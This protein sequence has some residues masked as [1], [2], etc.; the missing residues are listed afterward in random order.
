VI[1]G[2]RAGAVGVETFDDR[3]PVG[4]VEQDG[5]LVVGLDGEVDDGVIERDV[6]VG[7]T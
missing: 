3:V 2:R 5:D 4:A 1:A 7:C 6:P